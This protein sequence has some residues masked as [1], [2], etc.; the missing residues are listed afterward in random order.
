M[1]DEFQNDRKT[2]QWFCSPVD[3]DKGKE[4]MFYDIPFR[5]CWRIMTER[6]WN[7]NP[8]PLALN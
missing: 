1:R 8:E 4:L 3:R 5:G 7:T 2:G 6:Y